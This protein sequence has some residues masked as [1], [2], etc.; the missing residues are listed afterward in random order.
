VR[1][2]VFVTAMGIA[3]PPKVRATFNDPAVLLG[4]LAFLSVL[5][6]MW[7]T[8]GELIL[9]GLA[10]LFDYRGALGRADVPGRVAIPAAAIES[11]SEAQAPAR[12]PAA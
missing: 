6:R 4:F 9:A 1:E 8:S 7:A 12:L 11:D 10:Y 5:L 3:L 2:L